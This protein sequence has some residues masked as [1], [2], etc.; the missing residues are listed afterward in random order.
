MD[1]GQGAPTSGAGRFEVLDFGLV[2]TLAELDSERLA[3]GTPVYMSPAQASDRPIGEAGDWYGGGG[4]LL[5]GLIHAPEAGLL[6]I[7]ADEP[8]LG[9]GVLPQLCTGVRAAEIRA[10]VV[11]DRP[12]VVPVRPT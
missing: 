9:V 12:G 10:I 5:S 1:G 3:V 11:P 7:V 4:A 6:V 2:A 8:A